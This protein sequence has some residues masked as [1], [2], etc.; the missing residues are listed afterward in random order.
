MSQCLELIP[1]ALHNGSLMI[2]LLCLQCHLTFTK[3]LQPSLCNHCLHHLIPNGQTGKKKKSILLDIDQNHIGIPGRIM[4]F[5]QNYSAGASFKGSC[6][7]WFLLMF[8][9]T[10]PTEVLEGRHLCLY[11]SFAALSTLNQRL[12]HLIR[13]M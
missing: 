8:L 2:S 4:H 5:L 9:Q 7:V 6:N 10:R 3:S 12:K 1:I 11:S 13:I